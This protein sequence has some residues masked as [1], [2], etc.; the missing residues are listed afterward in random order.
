MLPPVFHGL[1]FLAHNSEKLRLV[2]CAGRRGN[3]AIRQHRLGKTG[4]KPGRVTLGKAIFV[5][6]MRSGTG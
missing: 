6:H 1:D 5:V 4:I 3:K 2:T